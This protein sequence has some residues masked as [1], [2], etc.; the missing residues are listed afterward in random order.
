MESYFRKSHALKSGERD[1]S[2][3]KSQ[4]RSQS[5]EPVRSRSIDVNPVDPSVQT[6]EVK[7]VAYQNDVC[8]LKKSVEEVKNLVN[9][10]QNDI[11][12]KVEELQKL[13]NESKQDQEQAKAE[14]TKQK[15]DSFVV[16][17]N[18]NEKAHS[19]ALLALQNIIDGLSERIKVVEEIL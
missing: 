9:A 15:L 5:I 16:A 1:M 14:R 3:V 11:S 13:I 7:K 8:E 6:K 19:D 2:V 18:E 10:K 4:S 12:T 17:Y